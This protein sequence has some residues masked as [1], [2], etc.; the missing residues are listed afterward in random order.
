MVQKTI[1]TNK[2]SEKIRLPLLVIFYEVY[3][4]DDYTWYINFITTFYYP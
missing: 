1:M 2:S 4:E 3:F